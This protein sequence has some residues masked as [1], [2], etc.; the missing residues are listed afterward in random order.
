MNLLTL[1]LVTCLNGLVK[2]S[3][4]FFQELAPFSKNIWHPLED[5]R[6]AIRMT[7][8]KEVDLGV[9]PKKIGVWG[10]SAGGHLASTVATTFDPGDAKSDDPI[11]RMISRPDFAIYFT[12]LS[13]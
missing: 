10:F 3:L 5:A 2:F 13:A 8:A 11:E 4:K 7:L 12:P 6:R 1:P 9:D